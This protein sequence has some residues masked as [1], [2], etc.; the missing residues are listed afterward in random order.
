MCWLR[1]ELKNF[2]SDTSAFYDWVI[3]N[4]G[5]RYLFYR[6]HSESSIWSWS[7]SY[8]HFPRK[9]SPWVPCFIRSGLRSN[10]GTLALIT[11]LASSSSSSEIFSCLPM[12]VR[13]F[14]IPEPSQNSP[15]P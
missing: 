2:Q 4:I 6:I 13:V 9:Y 11:A 7:H 5:L 3:F 12:I 8:S 10:D 15:Q 14:I 1:F